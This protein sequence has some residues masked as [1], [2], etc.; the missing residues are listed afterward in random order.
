MTYT[1]TVHAQIVVF[2]MLTFLWGEFSVLS[3]SIG[4]GG[5]GSG[6]T[7]G[8]VGLVVRLM[9]MLLLWL[10]GIGLLIVGTLRF[11]VGFVVGLI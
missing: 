6:V 8:L 3:D 9:L 7:R 4:A 10:I 2:T 1:T 5:L 11:L